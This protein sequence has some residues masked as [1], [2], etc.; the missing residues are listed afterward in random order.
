MF[1]ITVP[2]GARVNMAD[3]P[4]GTLG[5]IARECDL[6]WADIYVAPL[7]DDRAAA[8][9]YRTACERAGVDMPDPLTPTILLDAFDLSTPDEELPKSYADG[10]PKAE[11]GTTT[12]SSSQ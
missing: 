1:R 9:L 7:K 12:A 6:Q 4:I 3:L 11:E 2:G 8:M 10:L 5:D